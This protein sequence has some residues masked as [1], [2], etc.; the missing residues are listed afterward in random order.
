MKLDHSVYPEV[1]ESELPT[2]LKTVEEQ[3]DY[4]HR[5][6]S[7]WDFYGFP[8]ELTTLKLFSDWREAFESFPIA[9]SPAYCGLCD[10]LQFRHVEPEPYFGRLA[11]EVQDELE[12]RDPDP[13]LH[14]V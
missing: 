4:I 10:F 9:N 7:A 1:D 6:C 5:V 2:E 12:G 3:A 11:W 8:P 13:C 14:Q